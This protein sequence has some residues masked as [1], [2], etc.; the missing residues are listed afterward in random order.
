MLVGGVIAV[1]IMGLFDK[2]TYQKAR[3]EAIQ[4]GGEVQ[5]EKRLY[6]AM[7]GVILLPISLFVC[8]KSPITN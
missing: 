8:R 5:P 2:L 6:P 1:P 4:F 7:L 3:A